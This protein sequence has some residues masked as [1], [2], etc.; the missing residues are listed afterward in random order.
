[1]RPD[2]SAVSNRTFIPS[3]GVVKQFFGRKT[4]FILFFQLEPNWSGANRYAFRPCLR[5]SSDGL[6]AWAKILRSAR[7]SKSVKRVI[8][9][10]NTSLVISR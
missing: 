4:F 8:P 2:E 3:V 7:S 9:K 5:D 1:M 6:A 10:D